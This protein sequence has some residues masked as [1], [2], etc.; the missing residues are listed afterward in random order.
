MLESVND[1]VNTIEVGDM[2]DVDVDTMGILPVRVIE[3]LDDVS[4]YGSQDPRNPD[5]VT[6]SGPGFVGKIDPSSGEDGELVFA[7][8]QVVQGSKAKYF[9]PKL[10]TE[11]EDGST[12]NWDE[13]GRDVPNPYR[14]MA[15]SEITRSR[16]P[17]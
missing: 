7:L 13:Y 9:F 4:Q 8:D 1:D 17:R 14:K 3:L 16:E 2:V 6:M 11:L 5:W 12:S 10:G 15:G